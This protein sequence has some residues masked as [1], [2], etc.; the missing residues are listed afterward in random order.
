MTIENSTDDMET[1]NFT[2]IENIVSKAVEDVVKRFQANLPAPPT[3]DQS[4]EQISG[5]VTAVMKQ[6]LP[7]FGSIITA[8]LL[9]ITNSQKSAA[10][11]SQELNNF[12]EEMEHSITLIEE[13]RHQESCHIQEKLKF[14][15]FKSGQGTILTFP[16][17]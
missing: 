11:I 9:A 2:P 14:L 15:S 5:W 8:A 1:S 7:A 4:G 16:T 17:G 13:Q 10:V 3:A 6:M 12:K